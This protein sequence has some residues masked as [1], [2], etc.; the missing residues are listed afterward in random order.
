MAENLVY[1]I[2]LNF[3]VEAYT[4][5]ARSTQQK[6]GI[7]SATFYGIRTNVQLAAY[8]FKIAS[9]RCSLMMAMYDPPNRKLPTKG[10]I[11][12]T[13]KARLSYALGLVQGLD[14]DVK[15]GLKREKER[16]NEK[17]RKAQS[18]AKK[19]E[20]YHD[21]SDG[22]V[23]GYRNEDGVVA[24]YENGN[25][26][27][28]HEEKGVENIVNQLQR[29]KTAH[30]A[31]IDHHKKIASDVLKTAKIILCSARSRAS[32]SLDQKAYNRGVIDSKEIYLNQQAIK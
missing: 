20:S 12:E 2:S 28:D 14:Q 6:V 22:D 29:E 1:T 26:K 17:L 7:S 11:V 21:D 31:L 9:E 5:F 13:K 32:I 30:L 3:H 8:A 10:Q 23:D 27:I 4:T 25:F 15:E 18:A 16:R 24:G 19:G